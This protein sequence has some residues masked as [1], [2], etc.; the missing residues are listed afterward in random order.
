MSGAKNIP[1][2]IHSRESQGRNQQAFKV[3]FV[4]QFKML[5]NL[6]TRIHNRMKNDEKLKKRALG[7]NPQPLPS[8]WKK[9]EVMAL[10]MK[11]KFPEFRPLRPGL[12]TYHMHRMDHLAQEYLKYVPDEFNPSGYRAI[13][14]T[15]DGSECPSLINLSVNYLPQ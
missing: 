13:S 12:H 2:N 3:N 8:E 6:V 7:N 15:P 11:Q 9:L 1:S 5:Q 10:N 14:T 4:Q